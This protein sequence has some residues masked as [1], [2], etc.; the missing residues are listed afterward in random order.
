MQKRL[1][2]SVRK[3]I[4]ITE[5][6]RFQYEFNVFNVTNTTSPD[7]PQNQAQIRQNNGCSFSQISA[8][9]D[10]NCNT[11]RSYLGYGQVVTSN[12]PSDQ[13][14]ALANLDQV[15]VSNGHREGDAAS[16]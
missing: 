15:P 9:Y 1:D 13:Q 12:D 10:D 14:T 5:K 2:L 8:P 4:R 6:I 11:Y 3:G 7:V 16:A